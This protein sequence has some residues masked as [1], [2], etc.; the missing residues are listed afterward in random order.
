MAEGEGFEPSRR[1]PAYTLSK[2]APSATRPPLPCAPIREA[3][4]YTFMCQER[5]KVPQRMSHSPEHY[6][7]L[8]LNDNYFNRFLGC[9][10]GTI[11]E[12]S[13]TSPM[14][15]FLR[16]RDPIFALSCVYQRGDL[17]FCVA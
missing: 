9:W 5:N 16:Y 12:D 15:S 6:C 11:G 7:P 8:T 1:L 10:G 4:H 3:A 17:S 2:R 14:L 13:L